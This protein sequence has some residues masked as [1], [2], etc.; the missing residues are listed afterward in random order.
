M[1]KYKNNLL[2]DPIEIAKKLPAGMLMAM[3]VVAKDTK[4]IET[5]F[6][7]EKIIII[8]ENLEKILYSKSGILLL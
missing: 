4:Q 2:V 3:N 7:V 5:V 1:K 6:L 8:L